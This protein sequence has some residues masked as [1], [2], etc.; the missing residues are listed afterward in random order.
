MSDTARQPFTGRGPY[1]TLNIPDPDQGEETPRSHF[2]IV[3]DTDV[4]ILLSQLQRHQHFDDYFPLIQAYL[5]ANEEDYRILFHL[6]NLL[7]RRLEFWRQHHPTSYYGPPPD[8]FDMITQM[9]QSKSWDNDKNKVIARVHSA[10]K[11]NR[12]SHA[13]QRGSQRDPQDVHLSPSSAAH[14]QS[15]GPLSRSASARS[16]WHHYG[17]NFQQHPSL[18]T[19]SSY[20]GRGD[21]PVS[22][23]APSSATNGLRV[24]PPGSRFWCPFPNCEKHYWRQG[25]F[26]NHLSKSHGHLGISNVQTYLRP[27]PEDNSRRSDASGEHVITATSVNHTSFYMPLHALSMPNPS[28]PHAVSPMPENQPET[29]TPDSVGSDVVQTAGPDTDFD[30]VDLMNPWIPTSNTALHGGSFH[31][32]NAYANWSHFSNGQSYLDPN[33]QPYPSHFPPG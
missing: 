31:A 18:Q 33:Q 22:V 7:G 24:A 2:N 12:P 23:D 10:R 25:D 20:G 5:C 9:R 19:E 28:T 4:E 15:R 11:P 30:M 29:P 17:A 14:P 1:P 16:S 32:P 26:T 13:V 8:I 21:T 6:R 27:A 3:A